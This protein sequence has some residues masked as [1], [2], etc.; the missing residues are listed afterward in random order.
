LQAGIGDRGAVWDDLE[1]TTVQSVPHQFRTRNGFAK[2]R[3]T[4]SGADENA[5]KSTKLIDIL[6][7][8]TVWLQVRVLPGPPSKS[9]GCLYLDQFVGGL[10]H[11]GDDRHDTMTP[12]HAGRR[13]S[14]QPREFSQVLRQT[15]PYFFTMMG[16]LRI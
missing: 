9:N 10:A 4:R 1:T 5:A 7:L 14:A 11:G 6:P 13:D 3:Q 15:P 2:P 16:W 12:G 8:I